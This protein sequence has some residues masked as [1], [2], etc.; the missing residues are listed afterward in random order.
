MDFT[1]YGTEITENFKTAET[2]LY[3]ALF[4]DG[5]YYFDKEDFAHDE[6]YN[7]E[8]Y[9]PFLT[10]NLLEDLEIELPADLL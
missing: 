1:L 8:Y 4:N 2:S 5:E 7:H 10:G 3:Q 9:E 6:D